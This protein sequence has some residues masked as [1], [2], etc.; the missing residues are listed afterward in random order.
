MGPTYTMLSQTCL[1]NF[2]QMPHILTVY[3]QTQPEERKEQRSHTRYV[4]A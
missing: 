3:V 2:S 4:G 1:V